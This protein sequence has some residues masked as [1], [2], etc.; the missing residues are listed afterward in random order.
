[1]LE[2]IGS[3]YAYILGWPSLRRLHLGLFYLSA[4]AL[5]LLNYS[6]RRISGEHY[7]IRVA[8]A[9][10]ISPVVFDVGANEGHW[11]SSVLATSPTAQIHA[12]EP[13]PSLA[14]RLIASHPGV[15]VNAMA[16]GEEVNVLELFDYADH[17]GSQ[18]ASLLPGV[19]DKVYGK[20]A[21]SQT[22]PVGTIDDY[23][24]QHDVEKIDFLKIDVEGF[25]LNILRGAHRMLNDGRIGAIQFEFNY[26]NAVG[27]VFMRDFFSSLSAVYRY[28]RLLPHGLLPLDPKDTWTN[29]QFAF[30]NILALRGPT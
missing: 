1:M 11:L 19:I 22:V 7:A 23:C 28:Y 8:L 16:L 26:L 12:F 14:K 20:D 3:L 9:D 25:E 18:H 24:V 13:Q 2:K 30:Q 4:R 17:P 27:R 21:R 6:S 29:E 5:G 15:R 10:R